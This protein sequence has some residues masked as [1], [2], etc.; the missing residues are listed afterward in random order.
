MS[1]NTETIDNSYLLFIR[2]KEVLQN[3]ENVNTDMTIN[4]EA[5]ISRTNVMQDIHLQLNS[6]SIPHTFYNFSF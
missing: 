6:C 4:L 3:D 1:I 2:S 5:E